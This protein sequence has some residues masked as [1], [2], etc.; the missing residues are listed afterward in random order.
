[1]KTSQA[2]VP[3]SVSVPVLSDTYILRNAKLFAAV[4]TRTTK[5]MRTAGIKFVNSVPVLTNDNAK[6]LSAKG[7]SG[8]TLKKAHQSA[9]LFARYEKGT[10][11][12][13][14][15][16]D[17]KLSLA[18]DKYMLNN[19]ASKRQTIQAQLA[20]L[21]GKKVELPTFDN[22]STN[23]KE[24]R[25]TDKPETKKGADNKASSEKALTPTEKGAA[26]ITAEKANDKVDLLMG[27]FL[28]LTK[29]QRAAFCKAAGLM[30]DPN[31]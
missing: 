21:T 15:L 18:V 19:W 1:M 9:Q 28:K 23:R 4:A 16:F 13:V 30:V 6:M 20:G 2:T 11:R 10:V 24:I 27:G 7:L 8:E 12:V 3:T 29:A 26:A 31:A 25:F 17:D 5:T 22:K 14:G